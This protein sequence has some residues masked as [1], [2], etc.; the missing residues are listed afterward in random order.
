MPACRTSC[1]SYQQQEAKPCSRAER[2]QQTGQHR[3]S[4][5]PALLQFVGF[6]IAMLLPLAVW[7]WRA[8]SSAVDHIN[9]EDSGIAQA[10][11]PVAELDPGHAVSC[12][13][14]LTED[15]PPEDAVQLAACRHSFCRQC[16]QTFLLSQ[17]QQ[18]SPAMLRCMTPDCDAA[19]S[20]QECGDALQDHPPVSLPCW[21]SGSE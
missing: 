9:T 21:K 15:V 17:A 8:N 18:R 5:I 12:S 2:Q 13:V 6:T 11:R 7:S 1:T 19:I 3:S 4:K 20:M 14:C 16:L 10:I